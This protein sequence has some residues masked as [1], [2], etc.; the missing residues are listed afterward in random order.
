MGKNVKP[1]RFDKSDPD[2]EEKRRKNNEAIRRTR[3]KAKAKQEET[4][5]RLTS[6][7]QENDELEMKISSLGSQLSMMRDILEAHNSS[8]ETTSTASVPAIVQNHDNKHEL[9]KLI[10]EINQLNNQ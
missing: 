2:Y 7:K 9:F 3:A 6:I 1:R 4:L 10:S 5:N 8:Q